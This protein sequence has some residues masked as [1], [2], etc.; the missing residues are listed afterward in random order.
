M[1]KRAVNYGIH[2]EI[3]EKAKNPCQNNFAD[4]CPEWEEVKELIEKWE[5]VEKAEKL[6]LERLEDLSFTSKESFLSSF[7]KLWKKGSFEH[8]VEERLEKGHLPS[9]EPALAYAVK[10]CQI[11]SEHEVRLIGFKKGKL[12]R[13]HYVI[14]K[15]WLVAIDSKGFFRTA[16]P[17]VIPLQKWLEVRKLKMEEIKRMKANEEVKRAF[18]G[19]L[20]RIKVFQT[21]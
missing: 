6:L 3:L 1:A 10:I 19:I 18:E 9:K 17:L 11:L 15:D 20:R 8:H 14:A 4:E 12:H 2:E 13:V 21:R 7:S 16:F 5:E